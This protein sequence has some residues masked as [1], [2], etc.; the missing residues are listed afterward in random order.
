MIRQIDTSDLQAV[1]LKPRASNTHEIW[2]TAQQNAS[3]STINN[4]L[5]RFVLRVESNMTQ[6]LNLFHNQLQWLLRQQWKGNTSHH[7]EIA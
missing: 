5:Q 4:V 7:F 2:A 1:N 6:V 3:H